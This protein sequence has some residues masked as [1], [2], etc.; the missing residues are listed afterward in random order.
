MDMG[1]SELLQQQQQQQEM[2]LRGRGGSAI[3]EPMQRSVPSARLSQALLPAPSSTLQAGTPGMA[4]SA[5]SSSMTAALDTVKSRIA[6]ATH[7]VS[8]PG[9]AATPVALRIAGG[10]AA[11]AHGSESLAR[12]PVTGSHVPRTPLLDSAQHR[13]I[14]A[15][16]HWEQGV[17]GDSPVAVAEPLWTPKAREGI[18]R[19]GVFKP[20]N[21]HRDRDVPGI[22]SQAS[23][24]SRS[25][26]VQFSGA[27]PSLSALA[28]PQASDARGAAGQLPPRVASYQ[29]SSKLPKELSEPLKLMQQLAVQRPPHELTPRETAKPALLT[30]PSP[31]DPAAA[32]PRSAMRGTPAAAAASPSV[33][34]GLPSA[35]RR[36]AGGG[37]LSGGA[38]QPL[39]SAYDSMRSSAGSAGTF[40]G[41]GEATGVQLAS[42]AVGRPLLST[43]VVVDP[44][45]A[46]R[47]ARRYG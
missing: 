11:H 32:P 22:T 1:A 26:R 19:A 28:T 41:M 29:P 4:P 23:Q 37:S 6:A 9:R 25:G 36:S 5:L 35:S 46:R 20:L 17:R 30:V 3:T 14:D 33:S 39:G 24:A 34:A 44:A 8:T 13:P 27:S 15:G 7:T 45:Q 38:V 47:A 31:R 10:N 21:G 12:A 2:L 16:N 18:D 42:D 43:A 40:A